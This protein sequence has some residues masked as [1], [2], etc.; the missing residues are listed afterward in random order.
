M[1]E[2]QLNLHLL[3]RHKSSFGIGHGCSV[4]WSSTEEPCTH[5][6]RSEI[7]PTFEMKPIEATSIS[8]MDLT[9][10]KLAHGDDS[11]I[12]STCFSIVKS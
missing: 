1:D 10:R 4:N 6:I 7:V 12:F 11:F 3:Y 9:M 2:E 5:S 8:D